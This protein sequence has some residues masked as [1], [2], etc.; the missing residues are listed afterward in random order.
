[1]AVGQS[2]IPRLTVLLPRARPNRDFPRE[3]IQLLTWEMESL[4][5]AVKLR[6]ALSVELAIPSDEDCMLNVDR[7]WSAWTEVDCPKTVRYRN[8][9]LNTRNALYPNSGVLYS[10]SG[11]DPSPRQYQQQS[12]SHNHRRP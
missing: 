6:R 12:I 2:V 10:L 7:R 3:R 5:K 1:M 8:T 9:N 4:K 11:D